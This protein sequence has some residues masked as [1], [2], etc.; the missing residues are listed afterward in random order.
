MDYNSVD[1]GWSLR[2]LISDVLPDDTNK[3]LS[4]GPNLSSVGLELLQL[5]YFLVIRSFDLET[6][7]TSALVLLDLK[8]H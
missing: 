2:V 3:L 1:L 5:L 8:Q 7:V 4:S 6:E